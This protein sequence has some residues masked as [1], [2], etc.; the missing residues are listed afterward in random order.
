M[1][2]IT[3]EPLRKFLNLILLFVFIALAFIF[4]EFMENENKV[5]KGF[6]AGLNAELEGNYDEAIRLYESVEY[7][8][9]DLIGVWRFDFRARCYFLQ[10]KPFESLEVYIDLHKN[11]LPMGNNPDRLLLTYSHWLRE[12]ESSN[13]E[14]AL[15]HADSLNESFAKL[16]LKFGPIEEW[17][18]Y[19]SGT[20][21]SYVLKHC[22]LIK[23]GKT[24]EA[25]LLLEDYKSM[26]NSATDPLK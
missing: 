5:F 3:Y 23:L 12:Y 7:L 15:I 25:Q 13:F 24:D 22:T 6:E 4:F 26:Y 8:G 14:A 9:L 10:N 16:N 20:T 21:E 18:D 1:R 19:Y 11:K 2:I 17:E